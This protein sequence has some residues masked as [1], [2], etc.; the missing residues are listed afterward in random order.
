VHLAAFPGFFLTFL[1][2]AF[3]RELYL[4]ILQDP[5]GICYVCARAGTVGG[6]VA[7]TA[8]PAGLYS[9]LLRQRW[10]HFGLASST[11][12]LRRPTVIPRLLRAFT[13]PG[14]KAKPAGCA[15]L[16]SLAVRPDWQG[17]HCGRSLVAA[18]LDEATRRDVHHVS[19]DTDADD[20]QSANVFYQR[21]GFTLTRTYTTPEGRR[22]NEYVIELVR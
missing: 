1:G 15:V 11:A 8:Q 10:W 4:G 20:N 7:G 3:L 18:F 17:K 13:A 9:R 16:M 21:A 5:S 22:M 14:E 19:L 12:A 6:F 2:P